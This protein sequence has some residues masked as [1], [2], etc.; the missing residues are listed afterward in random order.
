MNSNLPGQKIVRSQPENLKRNFATDLTNLT[1][2]SSLD[3]ALNSNAVPLTMQEMIYLSKR[4]PKGELNVGSSHSIVQNVMKDFK[5]DFKYNKNSKTQIKFGENSTI[6]NDDKPK[7]LGDGIERICIG[8]KGV[9][10]LENFNQIHCSKGDIMNVM[11]GSKIDNAE[12]CKSLNEGTSNKTIDISNP[13][14]DKEKIK[15]VLNPNIV[16]GNSQKINADLSQSQKMWYNNNNVKRIN[17]QD[18][19]NANINNYYEEN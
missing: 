5:N 13:S 9:K 3:L 14:D 12:S 16:I 18:L 2:D 1:E 10:K 19:E 15:K 17:I 7:V 4:L 8:K 6:Q 11:I